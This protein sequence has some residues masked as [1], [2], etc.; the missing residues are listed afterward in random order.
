M[1]I[2]VDMRT[3]H[4]LRS[5]TPGLL[6]LLTLAPIAAC[7]DA[8]EPPPEVTTG[9]YHGF[10][11]RGWR[12]PGSAAE[13]RTMGRDLDGDG[14]VDN[15]AGNMIGGLVGLGLELDTAAAAAFTRGDVVA[16]HQLRADDLVNDDS[17]EW[18]TY[19]G[20]T[21]TAPRFD[22]SDRLEAR[23]ETGY[24]AG[25][26]HGGHAELAWGQTTIALPF[27]PDQSPIAFPLTDAKLSIDLTGGGCDGRLTGLV[28]G[29]EMEG[30]VL[31]SIALEMV[32]HIARHPGDELA[33]SAIQAFDSDRDGRL[34]VAEVLDGDLFQWLLSPDVD[35]DGDDKSDSVSFGLGF[36]CVPAT[37][38]PPAP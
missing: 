37:F 33:I 10:V 6:A 32:I 31:P 23:A 26:I 16:L 24:F 12:V 20:V 3:P 14:T 36:D 19:D 2:P 22:G 11:Q 1:A 9:A 8:T 4:L 25:S 18:R 21:G 17:V 34:T 28:P 30:L 7:T 38:S 27:F 29:V 35:G 15:N 13:A 5:A